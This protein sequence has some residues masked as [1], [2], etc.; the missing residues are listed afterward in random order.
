M[1]SSRPKI[2]FT[3]TTHRL[4]R[5]AVS[6]SAKLVDQI[7]D[8]CARFAPVKWRGEWEIGCAF[9]TD[10]AMRRLNLSYRGKDKTTDVLS[11][12]GDHQMGDEG[13]RNLGDI[14]ISIAQAKRQ[15]AEFHHP[16]QAEIARLMVHGIAHLIG[17]DHEL[18]PRQAKTMFAY[19]KKVIDQLPI[20][21]AV[22]HVSEH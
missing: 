16:V 4:N 9:V 14:V 18:G 15:A 8:Y 17:Y 3:I 6:V 12:E 7:A 19:E 21:L 13:Q 10:P 5:G 11:F 22:E 1:A 20:R 2:V